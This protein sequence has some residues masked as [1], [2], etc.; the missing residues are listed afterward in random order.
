VEVAW[1]K[2]L[3][4]VRFAASACPTCCRDQESPTYQPVF[5]NLLAEAVGLGIREYR[6]MKQGKKLIEE[7]ELWRHE[8]VL[9]F[10]VEQSQGMA[11]T[12]APSTI[13]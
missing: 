8:G 3:V 10:A 13:Q 6:R 2:S 9:T 12:R 7:I 1:G 4:A 11:M 5:N